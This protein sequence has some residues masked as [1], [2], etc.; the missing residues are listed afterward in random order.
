MSLAIA[1]HRPHW[2]ESPTGSFLIGAL[3]AGITPTTEPAADVAALAAL[4]AAGVPG[5]GDFA[6]EP[7]G[8]L[9]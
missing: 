5:A 1:L 6:F 8:A 7:A 4:A 9:F 3:L 2:Q